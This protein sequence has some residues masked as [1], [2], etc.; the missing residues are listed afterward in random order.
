M[1]CIYIYTFIFIWYTHTH[2]HPNSDVALSQYTTDEFFMVDHHVWT[3]DYV[4][5]RSYQ[6]VDKANTFLDRKTMRKSFAL[7]METLSDKGYTCKTR[8]FPSCLLSKKGFGCVPTPGRIWSI[9]FHSLC[10]TLHAMSQYLPT[11][12]NS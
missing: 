7:F 2:T 5:K 9:D 3:A 6:R 12:Y 1:I 11:S 10:H 4:E 8:V